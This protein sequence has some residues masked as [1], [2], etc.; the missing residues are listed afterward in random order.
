MANHW[1]VKH[2]QL[3]GNVPKLQSEQ[4]G[5]DAI[6]QKMKPEDGGGSISV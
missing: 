3:H 1:D 6:E 5:N 2:A 4:I